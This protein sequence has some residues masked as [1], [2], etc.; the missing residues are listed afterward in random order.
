MAAKGIYTRVIAVIHCGRWFG[1]IRSLGCLALSAVT[2]VASGQAQQTTNKAFFLPKSPVAAAY[3]LGRLS[4]KELSEAPRSE[5]VYVALL[6]RQGLE[7]KYRVEAVEGLAKIRNTDALT[8]LLGGIRELDKKGEASEAVLRD[9]VPVLLQSSSERLTAKRADIETLATEA[10]LAATRQMAY[11]ALVTGAGD[12]EPVW[13]SAALNQKQLADLLGAVPLI[14]DEKLRAMFFAKVEPLLHQADSVEV[15]R[16]AITVVSAIPGHDV[17][18]FST[19]AALMNSG[20]ERDAAIASLQR[21]PRKFWPKE[22]A[23]SLIESLV[24]YLE[25]MPVEKRTESEAINAFQFATDLALLLPPDQAGPVTKSLRGLGV[26]VFVIRTIP[27]QMLYDKTLIVVEAGKPVSIVLINEDTMP[28]NAVVVRPGTLEE[29]GA[30]AEKMPPEADARGRLYIPD[31][32]NVLHA[33]KMIDPGQQAKL[34][35][36][37]PKQTGDY[38]YVCTFPGH[39]RRMVGTLAVVTNAEAYLASHAAAASPK[40]TEWKT[41]DLSAGLS[42]LDSGRNIAGGKDSFTKLACASCHKLGAEGV[43]YGPELTDVF[44]RYQNRPLEVLR[45]IIEPSL[46][47][48]NRYRGF[49]FELKNSDE[50]SGMIVKEEGELLTVQTG[51][52]AS[53]IQTLKKADI[54]TQKPQKSSL[55][56]QGLLNSLSGDEILDLLAFIKAGG[57]VPAHQHQH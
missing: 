7:R 27:E 26:S 57:I 37:A 31:S 19:L 8:E 21:I 10:Q 22:S 16:A 33:T 32:P 14:R 49:D 3:V 47:V 41:E 29:I 24:R 20:T 54:K 15:R 2:I 18:V 50:L 46:V 11:A 5:P 36:I 51:P 56:P 12:S 45:Q 38:Q 48:S 35:F 55:M 28:H 25:S 44:L 39:W 1:L 53:L 30:A 23:H 6:Q 13:K 42:K 9:L 43:N 17:E 40:I 4:N 52:A 34:S